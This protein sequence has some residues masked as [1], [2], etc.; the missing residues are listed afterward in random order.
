[1]RKDTDRP[2]NQEPKTARR[3]MLAGALLGGAM[4][5]RLEKAQAAEASPGALKPVDPS[6]YIYTTCLQCNTGCE[7]KVRIQD[8]L[9]VKIEGNPYGPRAMDPHIDWSTPASQAARIHGYICPKGQ[10]GIQ[11]T[12]DPYRVTKVLKRAGARGEGK[13]VTIPFEQAVTEI[14]EGGVLFPQDGGKRVAGFRELYALKDPA[15]YQG[16]GG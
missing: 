11:T 15:A 13:W 2:A 10:A 5:A 8:G 6:Q 16:H 7:I 12:Y 1:M 4:L 14:V 3:E 9:A